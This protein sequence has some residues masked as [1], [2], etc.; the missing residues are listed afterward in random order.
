MKDIKNLSIWVPKVDGGWGWIVVLGSFLVHVFADGIVYSF[1]I[2]LN[3][4]INEFNSNN[5]ETSLIV[6][7]LAGITLAVGPIA[8]AFANKF[9]CRLTTIVGSMISTIGCLASLRAQSVQYL[10]ISVGCIMGVGAGFMYC[11]A[12]I[13]VTVY[14]EKKRAMATGMAVCGAGVGTLVFAPLAAKAISIWGWHGAFYLYSVV[15]ILCALCGATFR[16]LPFV[17]V[18]PNEEKNENKVTSQKN[19]LTDPDKLNGTI[20]V[21]GFETK[22]LLEKSSRPYLSEDALDFAVGNEHKQD[23]KKTKSLFD[24]SERPSVLESTG[25]LHIK[26]IFYTGSIASLKKSGNENFRSLTQ[27]QSRKVTTVG[28]Y[29]DTNN[30]DVDTEESNR[31]R[32]IFR[33]INKILDLTLLADPVF[34]LFSISNFLTSIG[35][36]APLMF[37]PAHAENLN[38]SQTNCA[39]LL[40]TFGA[41]NTLGR[42]MFGIISDKKLPTRFGK[43]VKRNRLWIYILSLCVCGTVTSFVFAYRSYASLLGYAAVFGLTISSYVCLTSV[44]LVDLLGLEKLTSAFGIL[45]LFQGI[46]TFVGPPVSGKLADMTGRSYDLTFV[47]CGVCLAISGVILFAIYPIQRRRLSSNDGVEEKS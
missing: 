2:L 6:G 17:K 39:Y 34:L 12:I 42:V 22:A 41:F 14:F 35:F 30:N 36:N 43:D 4:F 26:D 9:G 18:D 8:S 3:I 27:L 32:E 31:M 29:G 21:K 24:V 45:L 7:L 25:F 11:P 23:V 47:F 15:L 20:S 19:P 1:G 37:I 13:I 33:S 40:S 46:A 5:A 28:S 10:W 38:I 44:L 16:P